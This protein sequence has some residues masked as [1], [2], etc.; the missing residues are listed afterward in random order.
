MGRVRRVNDMQLEEVIL[1]ESGYVAVAFVAY[2]SVP[3]DHFTPEF[4][5]LEGCL[6]HPVRLLELDAVENPAISEFYQ[7]IATPTTLLLKEAEVLARWE[8]PYS[9]EALGDRI[10][11]VIDKGGRAGRS[12]SG[13]GKGG[14]PRP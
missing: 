4:Q 14:A 2:A 6:R 7:V 1:N 13:G 8:G 12:G 3:C 5:N 9:K 11:Q 10:N